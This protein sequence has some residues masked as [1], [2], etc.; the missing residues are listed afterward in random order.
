MA[1]P[2]SYSRAIALSRKIAL[3]V[4]T[5]LFY[6]ERAR[7]VALSHTL[8]DN[9][10]LIAAAMAIV[11]AQ[12]DSPGHGMNHV[13]KVAI[14]SG[15]LMLIEAG[16][17]PERALH[18]QVLLAQVAGLFHDIRRE[19]RS[20]AR[21]GAKA[22][23]RLLAPFPLNAG[24]RADIAQAIR[25]HEAFHPCRDGAAK[26]AQMLSDCLYDADKFRWG[27]DNFT[28]TLWAMAI[29]GGL[30]LEALLPR[31]GSGMEKIESIRESFR[32]AT[33]KRYGPDFIDRGLTIGRRLQAAL[34][35]NATGETPCR[36]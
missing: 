36:H 27:P 16:A 5:P 8:F 6:R 12:G 34:T 7:E 4:G 18:R 31:F 29:P 32:T 24:E 21:Q 15:A 10:P 1:D 28:D 22:A 14:D 23:E 19:K 9:E 17:L 11:E 20:H 35:E 13:R 3:A 30:P 26:S 2:S 25:N 33:G